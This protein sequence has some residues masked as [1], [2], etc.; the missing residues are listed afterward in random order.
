M[1]TARACS[2]A[3]HQA[4]VWEKPSARNWF[5]PFV[6]LGGD[7]GDQ[8]RNALDEHKKKQLT[9][10]TVVFYSDKQRSPK[11]RPGARRCRGR[12]V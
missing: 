1:P 4:S 11:S 8:Y 2:H 12:R 7:S 3:R 9:I 10:I 6:L 5:T